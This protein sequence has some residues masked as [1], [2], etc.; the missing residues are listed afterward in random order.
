MNPVYRFTLNG[1]DAKP[2]YGEDLAKVFE[3]ESGEEF[4]RAK[5]NNPLTFI[6][7]DYDS[8]MGEAFDYEH[9]VVVYISYDRGGTWSEYWRGKF[10]RTDCKIN[11]DDKVIEVTPSVDD[12]YSNVLNGMEKEYDLITLAPELEEVLLDKRGMIQIYTPGESVVG[13]FLSG[14]SWEEQCSPQEDTSVLIQTGDRKPNFYK[15]MTVRFAQITNRSDITDGFYT[16]FIAANQDYQC[17]SDGYILK[18]DCQATTPWTQIWEIIRASDNVVLWR[19]TIHPNVPQDPAMIVLSPV[20]GSGAT[21]DV[22][23]EFDDAEILARY[24]CDVEMINNLPTYELPTDDF[25]FNNRNYHR[26]RV[27]ENEEAISVGNRLTSTPTKWGIFQPGSYYLEPESVSGEEYFPIA[28]TYWSRF[29]LW[30]NFLEIDQSYE[31]ASRKRIKLKNAYPLYSAIK[32]LLRQFAPNITHSG[33]IAY[34]RFLY[35]ENPL[36]SDE[37]YWFIT[38]K[39]NI[40]VGEYDQPAQ[41]APVTLREILDMLRDCFR[42]Y[43]FIEDGKFR[44]EHIIYFMQGGN[45]APIPS[46]IQRDLTVEKVMR[47]GKEW[48]YC[49]S[50][51]S[52]DKVQMPERYEFGWMDVATK[53]F[54]GFPIDITSNY[55]DKGNIRKVSV[56]SFSSDVDYLMLEPSGASNDGFALLGAITPPKTNLV[57][58]PTSNRALLVTGAT[59][60][61][62]GCSV[63]EYIPVNGKNVRANTPSTPYP[64]SLMCDYCVYDEN[65]NC[66]RFGYGDTYYYQVG[67]VYVRFTLDSTN[68]LAYYFYYILPYY[69]YAVGPNDHYLQNGLAAFVYLERFYLYDLPA[70]NYSIENNPGIALGVKKTKAQTL[71]FPCYYDLNLVN[72]IK[73][74]MGNGKI[75]KISLNLSS[76]NANVELMYD[77]E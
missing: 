54:D 60:V 19:Y 15:L 44:I 11:E 32:V 8:I 1:V 2:I 58:S 52:F 51:Y 22:T 6:K 43:W 20:S 14:M 76:R 39:S 16:K 45:Y 42:C 69:N 28:K 68:T 77:T 3:K 31:E 75:E 29:S 38:P 71:N 41:K 63:S 30:F 34:S 55:V 47:N 4:F 66:I 40:L 56:Q 72:L 10:W 59:S 61:E 65:Q 5:L 53:Y 48:S 35:G 74:N 21:G 24:I 9:S 27:Y 17:S 26:V 46:A 18:Y 57:S 73:T 25:V 7:S 64:V 37:I 33:S 50:K 13:C 36:T 70:R 49:T 67:D 23:I 12:E 62:I